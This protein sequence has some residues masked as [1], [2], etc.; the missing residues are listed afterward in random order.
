MPRSRRVPLG[1]L[2]TLLALGVVACDS[3]GSAIREALPEHQR[4]LFDQGSRVA[5]P[6]W[7]C[8][9]FYGNDHKIGPAL[10]GIFGFYFPLVFGTFTVSSYIMI[11]LQG[12][13]YFTAYQAWA[14]LEDP[15]KW[16]H[17][18]W[19]VYNYMLVFGAF[20]WRII[21][22]TL[23]GSPGMISMRVTLPTSTPR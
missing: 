5:V 1:L 19:M 18:Q 23:I 11:T 21:F 8:H 17:R 9:D 4:D 22:C 15:D 7:A 14:H 20:L 6:C 12:L 3:R 2:S 13:V 16:E 10:G